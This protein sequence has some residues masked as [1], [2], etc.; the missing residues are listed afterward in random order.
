MWIT[1][2]V[3][4][5]LVLNF[6]KHGS[7]MLL[8]LMTTDSVFSAFNFF[9]MYLTGRYTKKDMINRSASMYSVGLI[10][11]YVLYLTYGLIYQ[12]IFSV[13]WMSSFPIVSIV[14]AFILNIP[15]IQNY[16][17]SNI[18]G[19]YMKKIESVRKKIVIELLSKQLAGVLNNV[20]KNFLGRK[21]RK[22]RGSDKKEKIEKIVV[23]TDVIHL[24]DDYNRTLSNIGTIVKNTLVVVIMTYLRI[25][26][27]YSHSVVKRIYSY[28][29]GENIE[30]IT[31]K[32]A[33]VL[34]NKIFDDKEWDK[35][36]EPDFIQA[37]VMLYLN[38]EFKNK[39]NAF[40]KTITKINYSIGKFFAV[41]TISPYIHMFLE[42]LINYYHIP[43]VSMIP[44]NPAIIGPLIFSAMYYHRWRKV[45]TYSKITIMK[46]VSLSLGLLLSFFSKSFALVC[47]VSEFAYYLL[48]NRVTYTLYR[49][50]I[51][52]SALI[53]ERYKNL[54]LYDELLVLFHM[55]CGISMYF[56]VGTVNIH[57]LFAFAAL[58]SISLLIASIND[59]RRVSP[60]VSVLLTGIFS[61]YNPIHIVL[62]IHHYYLLYNYIYSNHFYDTM[63]YIKYR[64]DYRIGKYLESY[65]RDML[66]NEKERHRRELQSTADNNRPIK[67]SLEELDRAFETDSEDEAEPELGLD[68]F[69]EHF[70]NKNTDKK[71]TGNKKGGNMMNRSQYVRK[72]A[73]PVL[74]DSYLNINN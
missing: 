32:D 71:S 73:N 22:K 17:T 39:N 74:I 18:I 15:P 8:Y 19:G 67:I 26:R 28:K 51:T 30:A 24:F 34:L 3:L 53:N 54:S 60:L 21:K 25:S 68:T 9:Y 38:D 13:F 36:L 20:A 47:F 48:F 56:V 5:I 14:L 50:T 41:W 72:V 70:I 7:V 40:S 65:R 49:T 57:Y 66:L 12:T 42:W 29:T 46:L 52:K 45:K 37:L 27:P 64:G 1:I 2:F 43:Y 63:Y 58:M 35:L 59:M 62:N 55:A 4:S 16:I 23:Y 31:K 61:G 44:V 69:N 10:D 6:I 33:K 11:R